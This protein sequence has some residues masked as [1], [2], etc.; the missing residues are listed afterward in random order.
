M[1]LQNDD[2]FVVQRG[3]RLFNVPSSAL[4]SEYSSTAQVY[5]GDNPP[6]NP[7]EGDLWWSSIESN[8]FI[9]YDDGNSQQWVDASPAFVDLDY[10]RI[11]AYIEEYV[12][13]NSVSQIINGQDITVSPTNGKGVVT[14]SFDRSYLNE[15]Q[16]RQDS[17]IQ[18]LDDRVTEIEENGGG[19]TPIP[20]I[21][22]DV[23]ITGDNKV[24]DTLTATVSNLAGGTAP[25][26]KTYVWKSGGVVDSSATTSTRVNANSDIGQVITCDIT[27]AEPDGSNPVIKTAT[28]SQT[29]ELG[30]AIDTPTVLT[31]P[32]GA[33]VGADPNN[34]NADTLEF[35]STPPAGTDIN[36]YGNATWQVDTDPNFGSAMTAT[37]ALVE[38][39]NQTLLPGERGAITL[40]DGTT[41][42]TRVKYDSTDPAIESAYSDVNEFKTAS[43]PDGWITVAAPEANM[44]CSIAYGNNK[45]VAVSQDGTNQVMYSPDGITWTAVPAAENNSWRSVTYGNNK[46]VAVSQNGTNRVMYSTD[47]ISWTAASAVSDSSWEAVT[48]GDNKFVAVAI[49]GTDSIMYST[50]GITWTAASAPEAGSWRSVTYG[51]N[52]FVAVGYDGTS[53][54]MYSPDGINWSPV[55]VEA[56]SWRS[57]TYGNN[58]FVAVSKDGTNRVMYSTDGITWTAVPASEDS[59]WNEVTYG[60]NK[61]VAVAYKGT[62]RVMYSP[63]GINWS[64]VAVE[65]SYWYAVTYG[66]NKFVA[67]ARTGSSQIMYSFTGEGPAARFLAYDETNGKAVN[68]LNIVA[69]YGVDPEGN[70]TDLG[71]YPLTEQPTYEV[72]GYLKLRNQFRPIRD[73]TNE[74]SQLRQ[75]VIELESDHETMN[76]NNGGGSSGY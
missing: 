53:R 34:P 4:K 56:N 42:Y 43:P 12:D 64:S 20:P 69:R 44:W 8:L 72:Q 29:I 30:G 74:L 17:L 52:K 62:N 76:N 24:G 22:F 9:W 23:A 61:F 59:D 58:K 16:L 70:N 47:G 45:F 19:G 60:N 15:D 41:Y 55:A 32:D 40:A 25:E 71:I 50:D 13:T 63:D 66:N 21:T 3:S 57:V 38:G 33:G 54:V 46:F 67:V 37:K 2:R 7:V 75:R 14:V 1:S 48:Y 73:F 11:N 28:Y 27:C 65:D 51:N 5:V 10:D 31:P 26:I 68:D 36:T 18:D 49:A 35:T 6:D 39:T